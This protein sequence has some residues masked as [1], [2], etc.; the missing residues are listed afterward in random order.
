M[1]GT[2]LLDLLQRLEV[3][4]HQASVRNDRAQHDHSRC[5]V[6]DLQI[7]PHWSPR[8]PDKPC[9]SIIYLEVQPRRLADAVPSRDADSAISAG[10]AGEGVGAILKGDR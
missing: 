3:S 8:Q 10:L 9:A 1:T 5:W 4:L 7:C 6:A 2:V